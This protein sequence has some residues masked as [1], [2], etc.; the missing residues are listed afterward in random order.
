MLIAGGILLDPYP[1]V[2][3]E[4]LHMK[5]WAAAVGGLLVGFGSRLGNGC[6]SGFGV[7]GLPRFSLRA[8]VAV[9]VFM[10]TGVI[11]AGLTRASFSRSKF[12]DVPSSPSEAANP[13][14]YGWTLGD[15]NQY[16]ILPLVGVLVGSFILL[17]LPRTIDFIR[18][19]FSGDADAATCTKG[20]G[21]PPLS[22]SASNAVAATHHAHR[23]NHYQGHMDIR[24][25]DPEVGLP[26]PTPTDGSSTTTATATDIDTT[27]ES[28]PLKAAAA[29]SGDASNSTASA[30]PSK[31]SFAAVLMAQAVALFSGLGFGLALVLSGM[32]DPSK[33]LHFLDFAGTDGWDPQLLLV[34]GGAVMV[35]AAIFW[36]ALSPS[37]P[38]AFRTR[39]PRFF[40][41]L[42]DPGT[43]PKAAHE[44]IPYGFRHP[45]NRV[46]S[47]QL[48]LGT[49]VFGAGWGLCGVCPGPGIVD[50]VSGKP[51]FGVAIPA[52][53]AGMAIHTFLRD[54]RL[55]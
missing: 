25:D 18:A 29:T 47:W 1:S 11:V 30:A 42:S 53:F 40:L 49:A 20:A 3:G 50:Y 5:P 14:S 19:K 24:H 37:S 10:T 13:E 7:L 15:K 44:L 55:L 2:F 22:P 43:A 6:T 12:Y 36:Y 46:F 17:N 54:I 26:E 21:E 8:F 41:A 38:S 9:S 31:H 4:T 35:N 48:L 23:L 16:Y 34:M 52:I 32:T 51:H 27:R 28:S 39:V 33:V 45:D